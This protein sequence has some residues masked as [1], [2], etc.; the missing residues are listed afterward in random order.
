M[1]PPGDLVFTSVAE[2]PVP[3]M[4]DLEPQEGWGRNWGSAGGGVHMGVRVCLCLC[5]CEC[6]GLS[7]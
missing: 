1:G 5:V 4:F 2:A 3:A 6:V 7:E